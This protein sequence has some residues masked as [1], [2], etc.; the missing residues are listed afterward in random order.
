MGASRFHRV[1]VLKGG[2]SAER[3]VS[4]RSGAAVG[5]GLRE[6]GYEVVEVDVA[7]VDLALPKGIEAVF[8][9]LHG[10][11]GEDGAMQAVLRE[12]GLPYTGSNEAASRAAFDK[13]ESKRIL[14]EQAIPTPDYELLKRG[15]VCA[16]PLP[17]VVKPPC[18]GS[19]IGVHR[20]ACLDEWAEALADAFKYG[21]AV[22]A[23]KY[24]PGRELTVGIVG[25]QALPVVEI[26]APD[27]W[28]DYQAKYT[29]GACCYKVPAPL[30]P[31]VAAHCRELALRTFRALGCR[32]L[33][34]VDFRLSPQ[35]KPY[36]L[37]LNSIP[38]FT[39]TSL[40]PMAAAEAGMGF[41]ALCDTIMQSA[42]I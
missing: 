30:D 11:L 34:R 28:Y 38:G 18:Q 3:D 41:A 39:E 37:E 42:G 15:Q 13:V 10:A 14:T 40:L 17:V 35:G 32:G 20:V 33:A 9:A 23:E 22:L 5:R 6:A 26:E 1:A 36:V 19:T 8:I 4:L 7:G 27:S 12:C 16:L 2:P 31:D 21:D 29:K 25:D 24:I